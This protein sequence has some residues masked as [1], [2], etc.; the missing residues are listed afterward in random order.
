MKIKKEVIMMIWVLLVLAIIF[1]YRCSIFI[2]KKIQMKQE[3]TLEIE[4]KIEVLDINESKKIVSFETNA[5]NL[6]EQQYK[7]YILGEKTGRK[8]N[9]HI[10]LK[11]GNDFIK[12][13]TKLKYY[14][15][16]QDRYTFYGY[17]TSKYLKEDVN[18]YVYNKDTNELI[19]VKGESNEE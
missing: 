7:N 11:D 5:Q 4:G 17:T 14:D 2:P 1:S 18:I 13:D 15:F 3:K 16:M 6:K 8:L 9:V 12:L 19:S 10:V